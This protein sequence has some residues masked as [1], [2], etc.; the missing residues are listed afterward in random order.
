MQKN[1]FQKNR[2]SYKLDVLT[3]GAATRDV[4][5]QSKR[6]K[7]I[8][9]PLAADGLDVCFP[10]GAKIDLDSVIFETGGGATNAAVTFSR[11]GLRTACAR[12]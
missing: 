9:N 1:P 7:N 3:V 12:A 4:F 5:I 8:K 11:F 10:L 2:K 6:F